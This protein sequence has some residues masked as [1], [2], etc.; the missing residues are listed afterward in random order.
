MSLPSPVAHRAAPLLLAGLLLATTACSAGPTGSGAD[1][2]AAAAPAQP[3]AASA[4]VRP[5]AQA[6]A[7]RAVTLRS[8]LESLLGAHVLVANE[9]VRAT[10]T[11]ETGR[12]QAAEAAVDRNQQQLVEAVT[13]LAGADAGQRLAAAW[14][15]HIDVLGAYA[16]ALQQGDAAA[17]VTLREQYSGAERQLAESFSA[18]VG[19]QVPLPALTAAATMHGEHLLDQADAFSS[20]AY[21]GAY[22]TQRT[23]FAHMIGA[24]DVLARGI[25]A[26]Q[27]LPTAEL[28]TPR[29]QLQTALSRLLAEHMG[30][31]VQAMRAAQDRSPDF[32]AA[33]RAVNANTSDLGAAIALWYGDPAGQEFL[34][35]WADHV[36]AL[37]GYAALQEPAARDAA[38]QDGVDYAPRLARFLAGATEQRLPTIELAAALTAHDDHLREQLDAY[39]T[40]DLAEAQAQA[41]QGYVHMF[42]LA[43]TLA[44]AIGDAVATKLPQGGAATGGGGHAAGH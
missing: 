3:A 14:A 21:D 20:R 32:A 9:F 7:P 29:R 28:D 15:N 11:G 23:A 34:S 5:R 18:V 41:E 13:A 44:M 30:L 10:L 25:A 8:D 37:I 27:G 22:A 6:E 36:E 43:Q 40:D 16:T 42:E 26:D 12:A 24:A 4:A 35:I 31:M 2:L 19:E 39:A 38:E 17:A 1:A 33:G